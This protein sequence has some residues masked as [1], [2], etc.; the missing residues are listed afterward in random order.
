ME[1]RD[2]VTADAQSSTPNTER[3]V[4]AVAPTPHES[5]IRPERRHTHTDARGGLSLSLGRR[6]HDTRAHTHVASERPARARAYIYAALPAS[7]ASDG[8]VEPRPRVEGGEGAAVELGAVR[9]NKFE[10]SGNRHGQVEIVF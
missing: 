1:R 6:T 3:K 4:W 7:L 9:I 2:T 10:K 8:A 5:A